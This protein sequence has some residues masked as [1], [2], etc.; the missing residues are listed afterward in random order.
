MS[1]PR[2]L[3]GAHTL[4]IDVNGKGRY[5]SPS[6]PMGY[7]QPS[8]SPPEVMDGGA[9]VGTSAVPSLTNSTAGSA[10]G[11]YDVS[12]GAGSSIDLMDL[13][14]DRL[15]GSFDP[16]PL[17]R[18]LATQAQTSGALNAKH[19]ELLALQAE[20]QRRLATSRANFADGMKAA[21]E[22]KKDLEWT[23]KRVSTLK[24]KTERKY[25]RQYKMAKD[26]CPSPSD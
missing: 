6:P 18:S 19:R 26:R 16:L 23:Q 5:E 4:P 7:R 21:K 1:S 20:A 17:D 8:M 10:S 9:S 22:V 13:L 12:S 14:N 3:Y 2:V 15:T 24:T 25:P 11:E